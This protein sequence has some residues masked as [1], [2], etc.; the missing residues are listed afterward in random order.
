MTH[1]VLLDVRG[2]Y[3][4]KPFKSVAI[5]AWT[6]F[7]KHV[8]QDCDLAYWVIEADSGTVKLSPRSTRINESSPHWESPNPIVVLVDGIVEAFQKQDQATYADL[9]AS[10]QRWVTAGV[11]ASFK[12]AEVARLFSDA[13]SVGQTFGIVTASHDEGIVSK[14]LA[15]IWSNDGKLTL[16]SIASAQAIAARQ[17]APKRNVRKLRKR[18]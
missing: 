4:A 13:V 7:F 3:P 9:R 1:P 18:R 2:S 8:D 17:R 16:S 10:F 6:L 12:S 14:D 11:L 15:L 5:R